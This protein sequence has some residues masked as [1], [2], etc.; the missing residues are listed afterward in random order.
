MFV[1]RSFNNDAAFKFFLGQAVVI[2]IEDHLVD[3]G[4][5]LG[6]KDS[7]FWRLAGFVWTVFTIGAM[8]QAWTA[9]VVDHGMWIH[10]RGIDVFGIGPPVAS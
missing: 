4:K 5:S 3:F 6:F 10:D 8:S 9:R 1:H 7:A 2:M